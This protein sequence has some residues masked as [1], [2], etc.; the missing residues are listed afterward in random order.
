MTDTWG[1]S[2]PTFLLAYGVIALAAWI[3]TTR[4]RRTL[5]RGEQP[6]YSTSGLSTRPHDVAYLNGG[7]DLA[8]FSALSALHLREAITS[9]RGTVTA[10]G[11]LDHGADELER[12]IHFATTSP[13]HRK[14]LQFHRTVADALAAIEARLVAAGLLLSEQQRR[15]IRNVGFW[16]LAVAALGFVR[17]LAGI[18][19]AKPVGFLIIETLAV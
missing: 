5:A 3:S 14:R 6:K 17:M 1:I 12:A 2:G 9:S 19:G 4:V 13:V 10:T 15:Q 11:R 16:M 8:I 7:P 18:A